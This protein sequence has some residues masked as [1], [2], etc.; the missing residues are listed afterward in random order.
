M[1]VRVSTTGYELALEISNFLFEKTGKHYETH[2]SGFVTNVTHEHAE[3][4]REHFKNSG[5]RLNGEYVE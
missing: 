2:T 5:I 1:G 3:I 4:I